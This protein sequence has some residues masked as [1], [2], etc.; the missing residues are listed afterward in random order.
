MG[1]ES[2]GALGL[3]FLG[4]VTDQGIK[5]YLDGL[6]KREKKVPKPKMGLLFHHLDNR[7]F[8]YGILSGRPWTVK[9]FHTLSIGVIGFLLWMLK[10]EMG[11][12][13]WGAA[14]FLS[15]GLSNLLDRYRRG[16]VLDYFS[17][18]FIKKSPVFN[19]ADILIF[20]GVLWTLIFSIEEGLG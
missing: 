14:L 17:F 9:L 12:S 1:I 20:L 19:L 7:G 13:D 2:R 5:L 18:G 11:L 3:F 6:W 10:E 15:G 8:I 4:L 16:A